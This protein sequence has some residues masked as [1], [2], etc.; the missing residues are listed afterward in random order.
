MELIMEKGLVHIYT[1]DGKGK[2][3]A[4]VGLACS[5][6]GHNLK[7][8]YVHFH[9]DP[10]KYGYCEID[11]LKKLG[12]TVL[13]FAK[14]HPFCDSGINKEQIKNE[15]ENALIFLSEKIKAESFDLLILDEIN[16]S[17]RDGFL[18]EKNLLEFVKSKP[19][20]LELVMTGREATQNLMDLADYVSFVQKLKHP[21]DKG[22][23]S[24]KGIEF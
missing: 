18:S 6:L 24:R 23:T 7:V 17:V 16:I 9:K 22:V 2:T 10:K 5:A 19:A 14:E 13:G 21:Y 11:N 4:A 15:V 3:T 12:A 20:K 1:G 8:C